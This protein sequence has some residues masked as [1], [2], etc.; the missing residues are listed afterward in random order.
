MGLSAGALHARDLKA[1]NLRLCVRED[2]K[3]AFIATPF[4]AGPF[5]AAVRADYKEQRVVFKTLL[6]KISDMEERNF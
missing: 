4:A 6:I 3:V 2:D 1:E 5:S